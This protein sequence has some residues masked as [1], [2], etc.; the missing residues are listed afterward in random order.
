[1]RLA[2]IAGIVA[3]LSFPVAPGAQ[4]GSDVARWLNTLVSYAR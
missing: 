3:F 1:M 4:A 2:A